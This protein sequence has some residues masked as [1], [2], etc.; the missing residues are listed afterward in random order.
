MKSQLKVGT[1]V[2]VNSNNPFGYSVPTGSFETIISDFDE[3]E[4]RKVL[5]DN[6]DLRSNDLS[7]SWTFHNE[8]IDFVPSFKVGDRVICTSN[9]F[10]PD[11]Y[12]FVGK[13]GTVHYVRSNSIFVNFDFEV[14]FLA[15]CNAS[16]LDFAPKKYEAVPIDTFTIYRTGDISDTHT[17]DQMNDPDEPQCFGVVFPSGKTVINWATAVASVSVFDNYDEF[18]RIHGHVD[19]EKDAAY[20][21][22]I[23]W[24]K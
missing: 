3:S 1:K 15:E 14:N 7:G 22:K 23:V 17:S 18:E 10:G 11:N 4:Y 5:L 24:N 19:P 13:V 9:E 12:F 6:P 2:K 21:T 20:G 16:E 8:E